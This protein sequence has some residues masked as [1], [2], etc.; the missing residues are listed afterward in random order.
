MNDLN[1]K[2]VDE[3]PRKAIMVHY[4]RLKIYKTQEK[5]FKPEPQSKRKTTVKEQKNTDLN[6]S[7]IDDIKGIESST[8]CESN[9]NTE[10]QSEAENANNSVNAKNELS[11]KEAEESQR[12]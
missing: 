9:L 12:E 8:D 5:P 6:S 4:D 1:F 11:E 7:D 3:K 10:N 2:V